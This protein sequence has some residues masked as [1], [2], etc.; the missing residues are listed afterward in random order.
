MQDYIGQEEDG[1]VIMQSEHDFAIENKIRHQILMGYQQR[2]LH[3]YE[4]AISAYFTTDSYARYMKQVVQI[5]ELASEFYRNHT[6]SDIEMMHMTY[7][8]IATYVK[9]INTT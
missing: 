4:K 8:K 5:Y 7:V 1:G 2:S 3:I 6:S 9:I